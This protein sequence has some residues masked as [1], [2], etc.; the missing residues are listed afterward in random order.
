M[1][2]EFKVIETQEQFNEA[3]S[4]RLQRERT[5]VEKKYEGFLSPEEVSKQTE[6]LNA[7]IVELTKSIETNAAAAKETENTLSA[8]I[9]ELTAANKIHE[10]NSVK[11][12]IAHE[13]GLSYDAVG[14]L[15]G[16]DEETIFKSAESL[17]GLIGTSGGVAP[18]ASTEHDNNS[19]E[20]AADFKQLL[21]NIRGEN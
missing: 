7:K 8:K 16:D 1:S 20:K 21:K 5:A 15:Q 10:T 14:F 4:G 17:K 9:A 19:T 12:R 18:L 13:A 3:I 6:S 11:I 2:E